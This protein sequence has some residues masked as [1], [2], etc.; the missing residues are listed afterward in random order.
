MTTKFPEGLDNFDVFAD[1][2]S[3]ENSSE[4][5]NKLRDAIEAIEG[6][7]GAEINGTKTD[8]DERLL[9]SFNADGTHKNWEAG[10]VFGNPREGGSGITVVFSGTY[11]SAPSVLINLNLAFPATFNQSNQ[12]IVCGIDAISTTQFTF[13]AVKINGGSVTTGTPGE[14]GYGWMAWAVESS[15]YDF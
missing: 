11:A 1:G 7:L 2:D 15:A 13:K 5:W 8:L 3:Q 12:G 9:V 4:L 14:A 10:Y 6:A